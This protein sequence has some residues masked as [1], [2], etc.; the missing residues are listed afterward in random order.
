M[1][2]SRGA[3]AVS[4]IPPWKVLAYVFGEIVPRLRKQ[5]ADSIKIF[6]GGVY[7]VSTLDLGVIME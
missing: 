3:S 2:I 4:F 6:K 5:V 7:A 1:A